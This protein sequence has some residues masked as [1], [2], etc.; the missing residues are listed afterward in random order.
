MRAGILAYVLVGIWTGMTAFDGGPFG[1]SPKLIGA[2]IGLVALLGLGVWQIK[3]KGLFMEFRNPSL[4]LLA[5]C[6][7]YAAGLLGIYLT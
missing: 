5:C 4:W 1:V 7:A 3:R 6:L 2:H